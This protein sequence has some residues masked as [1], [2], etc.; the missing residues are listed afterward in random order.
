MRPINPNWQNHKALQDEVA[1]YLRSKGFLV[2]CN[3]TYHESLDEAAVRAVR[4]WKFDPATRG[5]AAVNVV[6]EIPVE[7][8]VP[9][10]P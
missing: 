1:D 8:K 10:Q 9:K 6:V 5:G 2:R 4:R 7:F 3:T